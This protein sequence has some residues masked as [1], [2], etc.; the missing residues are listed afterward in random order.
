ML[1][2]PAAGFLNLYVRLTAEGELEVRRFTR[3]PF[4]A[5]PERGVTI[6]KPWDA[7]YSSLPI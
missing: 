5:Y 2:W 3:C 4:C 7:R 6:K 1:R